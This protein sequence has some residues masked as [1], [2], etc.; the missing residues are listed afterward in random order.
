MVGEGKRS[1]LLVGEEK[2]EGIPVN[3]TLNLRALQDKKVNLQQVPNLP[4]EA[5]TER[6]DRHGVEMDLVSPPTLSP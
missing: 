5:Q 4:L 3:K 2:R 1:V 6:E